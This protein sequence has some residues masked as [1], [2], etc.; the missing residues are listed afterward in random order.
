MSADTWRGTAAGYSGPPE[1]KRGELICVIIAGLALLLSPL[2]ALAGC[3]N[4]DR[5]RK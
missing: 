4:S 3:S 1:M 2:S 5:Q